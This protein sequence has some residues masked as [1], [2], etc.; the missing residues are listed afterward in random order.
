MNELVKRIS[1]EMCSNEN[2]PIIEKIGSYLLGLVNDMT[3]EAIQRFQ[4][5]KDKTIKGSIAA[6]RKEA[7]LTAVSGVGVIDDE[8]GYKIIRGYFGIE[9]TDIKPKSNVVNLN[10]YL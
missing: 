7:K 6:M 8:E 1:D 9:D 5:Q 10:D 4:E 3:A 2:N